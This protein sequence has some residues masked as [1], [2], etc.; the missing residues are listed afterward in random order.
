[1][2]TRICHQAH[3]SK[4]DFF[5]CLREAIIFKKIFY[6][7]VSKSGDLYDILMKVFFLVIFTMHIYS[8]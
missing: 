1:M 8:E 4:Y 3:T 7:N 2:L 5:K 6:E